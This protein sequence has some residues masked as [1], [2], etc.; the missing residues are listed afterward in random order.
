MGGPD[1]MGRKVRNFIAGTAHH[2]FVLR[3]TGSR[4]AGRDPWGAKCD[5]EDFVRVIH[6][7]PWGLI[8]AGGRYSHLLP[9][10]AP[11]NLGWI[12]SQITGRGPYAP[13]A[14]R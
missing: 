11:A 10:P 3:S 14:R 13:G 7:R 8:N 9:D 12:L 6:T 1:I 4:R 2:N 5:D